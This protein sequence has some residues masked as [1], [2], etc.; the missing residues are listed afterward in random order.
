MDVVRSAP[1]GAHSSQ[2]WELGRQYGVYGLAYTNSAPGQHYYYTVG[3]HTCVFYTRYVTPVRSP[4]VPLIVKW[5]D[6][7]QHTGHCFWL[8][9]TWFGELQTR[10]QTLPGACWW[11]PRMTEAALYFLPGYLVNPL[12]TV[13]FFAWELFIGN[14]WLL[15]KG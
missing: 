5:V 13:K 15:L 6:S 3:Q 14:E 8:E 4:V 11:S 1:Q 10:V 2:N 9:L 12:R 7:S